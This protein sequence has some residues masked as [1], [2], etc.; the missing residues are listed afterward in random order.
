MTGIETIALRGDAD[1]S[2]PYTIEMRIPAHTRIPPHLH[3]DDRVATVVSGTWYFGYGDA[4][5]AARLATLP[6]GS[7]YTEPAGQVHYAETHD[8][9]VVVQLTGQGPSGTTARASRMQP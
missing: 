6:A 5:D 2:G 1:R 9:A 8:T 7:F 4:F 3:P